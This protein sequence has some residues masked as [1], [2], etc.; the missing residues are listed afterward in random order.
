MGYIYVH[1][2]KY[3]VSD[4]KVKPTL[5]ISVNFEMHMKFKINFI[6]ICITFQI[7][8]VFTGARVLRSFNTFIYHNL[9]KWTKTFSQVL[10][11]FIVQFHNFIFHA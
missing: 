6:I 10:K 4:L 9:G 11:Y 8:Y 1:C 7:A 3:F 2:F 5:K